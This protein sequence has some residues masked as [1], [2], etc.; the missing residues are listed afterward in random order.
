MVTREKKRSGPNYRGG[1]G[2]KRAKSFWV[3]KRGERRR[4]KNQNSVVFCMKPGR[5][6]T[7]GEGKPHDLPKIGRFGVV[8][9]MTG[10]KLT[11]QKAGGTSSWGAVLG[12]PGRVERKEMSGKKA[13]V[14]RGHSTEKKKRGKKTL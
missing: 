11:C 5:A 4:G 2:E 3:E 12:K 13:K 1:E 14:V 9:L 7:G 6:S 8:K 10:G